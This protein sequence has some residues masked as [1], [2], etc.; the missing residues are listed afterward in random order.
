MYSYPQ[1]MPAACQLPSSTTPGSTFV[2]SRLAL[3]CWPPHNPKLRLALALHERSKLLPSQRAPLW[4]HQRVAWAMVLLPL[5]HA[6]WLP[7]MPSCRLCGAVPVCAA[8]DDARLADGHATSASVHAGK[9]TV[10]SSCC[11]LFVAFAA[12]AADAA[13]LNVRCTGV[14]AWGT[15]LW[16]P[17]QGPPSRAG[18][19]SRSHISNRV[20]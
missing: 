19:R 6:L 5:L 15:Q 11:V 20:R 8:L 16:T 3:C 13:S 4:Q 18:N 14:A 9:G 2:T 7:L 10:Q 17:W 1:R 12:A